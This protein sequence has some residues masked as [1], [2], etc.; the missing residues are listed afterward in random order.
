MKKVFITIDEL[1]ILKKI[2]EKT[3]GVY[4]FGSRVKGT[5]KKFSDL[6]I[7]IK[8]SQSISR[9]QLGNIREELEESHLPFVVDLSVYS[10]LPVSIQKSFDNENVLLDDAL[11]M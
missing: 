6:D 5:H 3:D 11:P 2:F 8:S 10:D 9:V 4:L 7:C 1:S